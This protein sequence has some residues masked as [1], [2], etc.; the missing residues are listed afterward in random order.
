MAL[1]AHRSRLP[2]CRPLAI[3]TDIPHHSRR[4]GARR[5]RTDQL[6]TTPLAWNS[7]YI[8]RSARKYVMGYPAPKPFPE[9]FGLQ[10]KFTR[11]FGKSH[12]S[13]LL[14]QNRNNPEALSLCFQRSSVAS[15][16]SIF[17]QSDFQIN[18]SAGWRRLASNPYF[19]HHLQC[20]VVRPHRPEDSKNQLDHGLNPLGRM[21]PP[22]G[23]RQ[24]T[25]NCRKSGSM[26]L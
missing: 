23:N 12:I 15:P 3:R 18:K 1:K 22:W 25:G 6:R 7:K 13:M 14:F 19:L 9:F 21:A 20:L 5:D 4:W 17:H 11:Q 26:A 10:N 8:R 2:I 16:S 24:Q